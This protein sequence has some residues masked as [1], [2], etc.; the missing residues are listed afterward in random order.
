ML[1]PSREN[2]ATEKCEY[3]E[4]LSL[5]YLFFLRADFF[6]SGS[7]GKN[8]LPGHFFRGSPG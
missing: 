5:E 3:S 1:S 7:C 8:I 6:C 4:G 2:P